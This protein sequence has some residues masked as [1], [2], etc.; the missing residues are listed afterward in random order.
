M[1][2]L[3]LTWLGNEGNPG[4]F[5][6]TFRILATIAA[7]RF[8]TNYGFFVMTHLFF[9][10]SGFMSGVQTD[11]CN[12]DCETDMY[13][14][15]FFAMV[16]LV[17]I[18]T[19]LIL[20]IVLLARTRYRIRS[21]YAIPERNC[22]GCEDCCCALWCTCCTVSQMA[23]H[24]ADYENYAALCCSETGLSPNAPSIV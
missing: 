21:R 24:T 12:S 15:L 22:S 18:P 23:R 5:V 7:V 20:F 16:R 13:T 8:C 4:R 10:K 1:H 19:F 11:G 2:R 14:A 9:E 6:A 17:L 3:K